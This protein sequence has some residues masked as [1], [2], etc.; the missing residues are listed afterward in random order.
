MEINEQVYLR[1]EAALRSETNLMELEARKLMRMIPGL[2]RS[3][4]EDYTVF[5]I[6]KSG[7]NGGRG[8]DQDGRAE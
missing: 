7:F 2:T 6:I 4:I 8:A 3:Q 5:E 1:A